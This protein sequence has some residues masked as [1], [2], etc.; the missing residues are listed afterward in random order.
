[1]ETAKPHEPDEKWPW[2]GWPL[3]VGVGLGVFALKAGG[4]WLIESLLRAL[5]APW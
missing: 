2:W 1:M 4:F 5:P 3:M